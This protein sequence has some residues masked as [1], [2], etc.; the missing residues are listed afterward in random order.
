MTLCYAVS[1]VVLTPEY[2]KAY[3]KEERMKNNDIYTTPELNDKLYLHY[4]GFRKI[5]ALE[6]YTGLK[7][8][9]LEGNGL[10]EISG[11]D[12]Q[13]KLRTLYLHENCIH[14]MKGLEALTELDTLNLCKN[15]I[16]SIA[17]LER[18]KKLQTLM[19]AHNHLATA[20]DLRHVLA[21]PSL[22]SLDLQHNRLD[23]V[24]VLGVL[25]ALPDLRVLYLMGNPV[26][27]QIRYYRK[28]VIAACPRLMY[29]DDRPVF[30]DER[31]RVDRWKQAFDET[32]DY[33]KAAEAERAEIVAI[34]DEKREA[35]QRNF[36]A[37]D[38]MVQE[39]KRTRDEREKAAEASRQT[40][41]VEHG[42]EKAGQATNDG[43]P[44]VVHPET[45]ALKA[46]R[47]ARRA[48][49]L[50]TT[51]A[52]APDPPA[53]GGG[54]FAAGAT[55]EEA[56]LERKDKEAKE[57]A[58]R[59]KTKA[60]LSE[61]IWPELVMVPLPATHVAT[62]PPAA[63][64]LLPPPPPLPPQSS[65]PISPPAAVSSAA[66]V[67]VAPPPPPRASTVVA[68]DFDELD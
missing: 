62:A 52:V 14:E 16:T 22:V 57:A 17:G 23:D 50:G 4:K 39:G 35:E 1:A 6:A 27:K 46:A 28:T 54:F 24:A 68:T 64:P 20:D 61:D 48:A 47:E 10:D 42:E 19:L 25:S 45:P 29:L 41:G 34:R 9:W 55:V 13:T 11:L 67:G 58:A 53:L 18:C 44:V 66:P 5:Q 59:S 65:S 56:T 2:L 21:V 36:R 40:H 8:I 30:V 49:I 32:G 7:V 60:L 51:A 26:V 3:C 12:N 33:E 31:R 38:A 63:M 15:F 37:F 43:E